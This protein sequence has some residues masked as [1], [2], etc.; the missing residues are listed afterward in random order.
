P[1]VPITTVPAPAASVPVA[2]APVRV[3]T[4][5]APAHEAPRLLT[6]PFVQPPPP[7]SGEPLTRI[8]FDRI[9]TQLPPDVFVLPPARLAE[10]LHEPGVLTVPSRHVLP[11][12]AEGA[13]DVPWAVI[14]YQSPE[15]A[16]ALPQAEVRR[17]FTGWNLSLPMDEV[18]SQIPPEMWRVA[19]PAPDLS[20][21]GQFPAPFA[22]GQATPE[23]Q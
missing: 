10:S 16:F 2:S 12:L 11:H 22:P 4:A 13:I 14:E 3:V 19:G 8:S 7:P 6:A 9:A 17:R 18:L 15:M 20:A 5:P 21:L 1:P 23:T